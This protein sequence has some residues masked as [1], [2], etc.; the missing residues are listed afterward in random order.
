[1]RRFMRK[2]R[3]L[4]M[5]Q[6]DAR[7]VEMN[8]QLKW[9]CDDVDNDRPCPC[10]KQDMDKDDMFDI[11]Y[12]LI[13]YKWTKQLVLQGFDTMEQTRAELVAFCGRMEECEQLDT[14]QSASRP[15]TQSAAKRGKRKS[16]DDNN[17]GHYCMLHGKD[18]GHSS[19]DCKVLMAQAKRMKGAYDSR[20]ES[21]RANLRKNNRHQK[22]ISSTAELNAF[23]S[24]S[25][26]KA[27]KQSLTEIGKRKRQKADVNVNEDT[28]EH[29]DDISESDLDQFNFEDLKVSMS[30][31]ESELDGV[32]L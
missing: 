8:E 12:H 4:S 17:D 24:A 19:A 6:Y 31:D 16:S 20:S 30:D 29:D 23:V 3:D 25:V 14:S 11:A 26:K 15:K 13:P 2:P 9:F 7:L 21:D 5:K 28:S 27:L 1:M 22:K 10:E 18:K 32:S